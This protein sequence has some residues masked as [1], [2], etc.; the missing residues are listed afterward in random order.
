MDGRWMGA[1]QTQRYTSVHNP[2]LTYHLDWGRRA[3]ILNLLH[4]GDGRVLAQSRLYPL[5]DDDF[6]H[7]RREHRTSNKFMINIYSESPSKAVFIIW[8]VNLE[9]KYFI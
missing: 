1:V 4:N 5:C 9:K 7:I 2:C 3:V 6:K 8:W